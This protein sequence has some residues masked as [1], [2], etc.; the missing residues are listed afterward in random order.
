MT[1]LSPSRPSAA[2]TIALSIAVVALLIP[3]ILAIAQVGLLGIFTSITSSW[4]SVQIFVDL[5]IVCVLALIWIYRDSRATGRTFWP[6][7]LLTL[8]AGGFG[9]LG[10]LIAGQIRARRA[11]DAAA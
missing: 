4:A 1:T 10:Y 8:A 5:L 11:A 7:L 6:W 2:A 3:T 9:V